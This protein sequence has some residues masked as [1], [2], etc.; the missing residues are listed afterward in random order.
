MNR[1]EFS[2]QLLAATAL[3]ATPAFAATTPAPRRMTIDLT[4]GAVGISGDLP[5][6]IRLAHAHGFESVQPDA[7]YLARQ[8]ADGVA[9]TLDLLQ[10][11]NLKWGAAGLPVEFRQSDAAFQKDID[12]LPRIAAAL[13]KANVT[14]IGT[15]LHPGHAS[16]DFA[17]NLE[18][19]ARRL[20]QTARI[21]QDHGLRLGLE[22]V[23]TPSLRSRVRHT[24]VYRLS[25]A[26]ELIRAID[27]PGTGLVL[28]SWHWW[29][30]GDTAEDLQ[31]LRNADVIAVDLNDA[32]AGVPLAEQQDNRRELP[33]ATGVIPVRDFLQALMAISYDGPIRAEPFNGPLNKLDNE[34][35]AA[36]VVASLR[37]AM[38]LV[39]PH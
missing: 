8:D 12:A 35:A 1:R 39:E 33:L 16:L 4:P 17:A 27:I 22:Y 20:R 11:S 23:G 28:D 34:A 19:H 25:Q 10:R 30:A 29:T 26:Q 21:L 15:W 36:A 9:R 3:A 24:F 32:P 5:E 14:R 31:R 2:R 37:K 7:D 18:Q 13:R 6:M 38:A